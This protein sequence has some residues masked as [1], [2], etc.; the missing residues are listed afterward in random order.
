[1]SR[2]KP[3]EGADVREFWAVMVADGEPRVWIECPTRRSA[4]LNAKFAR[5]KGF[6]VFVAK[7]VRYTAWKEGR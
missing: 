4:R 6:A 1:M 3:R 5:K 2:R 7:V